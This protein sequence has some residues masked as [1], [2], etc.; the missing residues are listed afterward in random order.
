MAKDIIRLAIFASGSGSNARA[1]CQHFK[2]LEDIKI[3][4]ILSNKAD[5]GVRQ[6]AEDHEVTFHFFSNEDFKSGN[7]IVDYLQS[8]HVHGIILAGFLRKISSP[9]LSTYKDRIINIHPA[10]LPKYGGKGMYGMNVHQAVHDAGENSSGPTIHV[11]NEN[12]D[13]GAILFQAHVELLPGDTPKTIAS[14]VLELEHKYYPKVAESYFRDLL[15][16]E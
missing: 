13:E 15:T 16:S 4:V 1:I 11:V 3:E 9:L 2:N 7:P 10:L 5:A 12:Y 6:V 8:L 14:K